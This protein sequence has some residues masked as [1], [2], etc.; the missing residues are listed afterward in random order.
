ME[1]FFQRFGRAPFVMSDKIIVI[2]ENGRKN[3]KIGLERIS[4]AYRMR[5]DCADRLK[6]ISESL[7]LS[8]T[9]TV[10][11]LIS[12]FSASNLQA[13]EIQKLEDEKLECQARIEKINSTISFL[14]S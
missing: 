13:L 12:D 8:N 1:Y 7:G 14:Q 4:V 3:G 6:A 5:K 11:K 10:E 9:A 2:N